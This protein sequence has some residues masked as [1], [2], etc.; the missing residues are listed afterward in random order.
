MAED[1]NIKDKK[2]KQMVLQHQQKMLSKKLAALK[3]IKS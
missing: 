1:K 2:Q 3:K